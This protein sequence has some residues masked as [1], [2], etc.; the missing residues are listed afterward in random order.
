MRSFDV[1]RTALGNSLRSKLRTFLT[2]IAIVVGAFTLTLTSGLGAG[3]NNYVGQIVDGVGDPNQMY[4]MASQQQSDSL[5][6]SGEP[7]EYDPQDT[8]GNGEF[9]MAALTDE[10]IEA[11]AERSEERRVGKECRAYGHGYE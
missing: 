11:I 4:V 7:V 10:D 9:G 8:S 2:V 6:G 1:A 3:I 5:A